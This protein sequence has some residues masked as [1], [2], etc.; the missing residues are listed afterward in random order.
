M[1][2]LVPVTVAFLVASLSLGSVISLS[3][4][5]ASAQSNSNSV[6]TSIGV[7]DTLIIPASQE[8]TVIN[9]KVVNNG[10]LVIG[11]Q[12]YAMGGLENRGIVIV[13]NGARLVS[14][15]LTN[16]PGALIKNDAG[17][18]IEFDGLTV[19]EGTIQN[20]GDL[21]GYEMNLV[22]NTD[23]KLD[24][25]GKVSN[26]GSVVRLLAGSTLNNNG[27]YFTADVGNTFNNGTITNYGLI[28]QGA[29]FLNNTG[30]IDNNV[31]ASIVVRKQTYGGGALENDGM[32]TNHAGATIVNLAK[33]GVGCGG[34]ID[35]SGTFAGNTIV[36][37][38]NPQQKPEPEPAP[39]Q[40]QQP[41]NTSVDE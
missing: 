38:C 40:Q 26:V 24:N 7:S 1:K 31:G 41:V 13:A 2:L 12:L 22:L 27:T 34:L 6:D 30:T 25:Y 23:S 11:G 14:Q 32:I 16:Y 29:G 33:V 28:S 19:N 8:P 9:S 15:G 39:Q 3:T 4:S 20:F 36:D 5:V 17:S 35:N 18:L 21:T 10:T 37:N